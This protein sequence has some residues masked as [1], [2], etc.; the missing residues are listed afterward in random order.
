M[1]DT[2]FVPA[3]SNNSNPIRLRFTATVGTSKYTST[4]QISDMHTSDQREKPVYISHIALV[5]EC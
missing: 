5:L 4:V 3:F 1:T 2:K